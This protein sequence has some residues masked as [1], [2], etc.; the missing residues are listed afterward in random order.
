MTNFAMA[1]E[2]TRAY[3]VHN[4]QRVDTGH[5]QGVTTEGRPDLETRELLGMSFECQVD[6][7]LDGLSHQIQPNLP[8]ADDHFEERVSRVPSNPGEQYKNW[9][10]WRGQATALE[11]VIMP[12]LRAEDW[13][14]LAA[15]IDGDGSISLK[16]KW[17]PRIKITQ[18]DREYLSRQYTKF[19]VGTVRDVEQPGAGHLIWR[20]SAIEEVRWVL[21]NCLPFLD[22]KKPTAEQALAMLQHSPTAR[23]LPTASRFTHTYQERYWPAGRGI[24]YDYGDLDDVVALL[25]RQPYTRQA[26]LPIFF[27]EDTGAVH[28]GRIPCT[29]GYQFMLRDDRL[30]MWYVI[31][32]CD[33]VR[34]FRD[35]LYLSARLLLWVLNELQEAE[36]QN[37]A[38]QVWVDV[39]PGIFHFHAFSLH[40][41]LGDEHLL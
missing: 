25:L 9:P 18:K 1:I 4:G 36:L 32:S 41:H 10:W 28:R 21:L 19:Q 27:P 5:W 39:K 37:D 33:Y 40:Y 35:D 30:H 11:E 29:L 13:A 17:H 12:E 7:S 8:W 34:H 22:L 14:Y 26:W 16:H 6:I 38:E 24:R 15:L 2:R 20:I 23:K 3:L 31:R